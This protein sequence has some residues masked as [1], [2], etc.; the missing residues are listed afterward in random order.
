VRSQCAIDVDQSDAKLSLGGDFTGPASNGRFALTGDDDEVT[1]EGATRLAPLAGDIPGVGA[2]A[3]P[4]AVGGAELKSLLEWSGIAVSSGNAEPPAL[5]DDTER[6]A[7]AEW[8]NSQGEPMTGRITVSDLAALRSRAESVKSKDGWTRIG[9][10]RAGWSAAYPA[11]LLPKASASGAERRFA[12]ADGKAVLVVPMEPG[13][14]DDGFSALVDKLAADAPDRSDKAYTR[15]NG[16]LDLSYVEAGRKVT[17]ACH[18]RAGRPREAHLHATGGSGRALVAVRSGAGDQF[19]GERRSE[20]ALTLGWGG[21][22]APFHVKARLV[23]AP[24]ALA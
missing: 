17:V 19:H 4:D 18:N 3:P 13:L 2:L 6:E 7:L 16:D 21:A 1:A 14:S 20:D 24:F 8:Q 5:P 22:P 12:N 23:P 15:V 9:D 11:A 10:E